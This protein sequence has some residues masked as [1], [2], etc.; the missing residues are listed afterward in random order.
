MSQ[1][2]RKVT[3]PE[4]DEPDVRRA[5]IV[6]GKERTV[7]PHEYFGKERTFAS[8]YAVEYKLRFR[9]MVCGCIRFWGSELVRN[10]Q[11]EAKTA[12]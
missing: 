11:P 3:R 2:P 1:R 5:V 7:T 6:C 4:G 12:L 10:W 9:C 8:R